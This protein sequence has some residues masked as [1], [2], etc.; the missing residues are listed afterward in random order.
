MKQVKSAIAI[1]PRSI[2]KELPL[3]GIFLLL[4]FVSYGQAKPLSITLNPTS[5]VINGQTYTAATM[6]AGNM[7]KGL[8]KPEQTDTLVASQLK[9]IIEYNKATL[10]K[11]VSKG[12]MLQQGKGTDRINKIVIYP[13]PDP[14]KRFIDYINTRFRGNLTLL[15]LKIDSNT[16][17]K[18]VQQFMSKY[19]FNLY[20]EFKNATL[21]VFD[22]KNG[23]RLL[24]V[25]F[26]FSGVTQKI[27]SIELQYYPAEQAKK[28]LVEYKDGRLYLNNSLLDSSANTTTQLKKIFGTPNS[29]MNLNYQSLNGYRYNAIYYL[30]DEIAG[31]SFTENPVN[32]SLLS[33]RLDFLTIRKEHDLGN[34]VI[35]L[36][37]NKKPFNPERA[38]ERGP[39]EVKTLYALDSITKTVVESERAT[40]IT[41]NSPNGQLIFQFSG[42]NVWDRQVYYVSYH[43][44]GLP[45]KS[46]QAE[47]PVDS[48]PGLYIKEGEV[49]LQKGSLKKYWK[50]DLPAYQVFQEIIGKPTAT[51]KSTVGIFPK[52]GMRMWVT[53]NG[54]LNSIQFYMAELINPY[55]KQNDAPGLFAGV[56]EVEGHKLTTETTLK[57]V[58]DLYPQYNIKKAYTDANHQVYVGTYSGVKLYFTFLNGN[59]KLIAVSV[60][61]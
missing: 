36:L 6:V 18:R 45:N 28:H 59:N 41:T 53:D 56:V 27:E 14:S 57:E 29:V 24:E 47:N 4:S 15:G 22:K 38:V 51:T 60:Y 30:Y 9:Y 42:T 32:N 54:Q 10:N 48:K 40:Y 43:L 34:P 49:W 52:N 7:F 13:N 17:I 26:S 20:E 3:F 1:P 5:M 37:V 50:S 19:D 16:S 61:K 44:P 35:Q 33:F 39:D 55:S 12:V 21:N 2:I 31:V 23:A 11:Y 46:T 8:G 58:Q 25:E